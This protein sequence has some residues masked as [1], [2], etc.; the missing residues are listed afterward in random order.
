VALKNYPRYIDPYI[1]DTGRD[2]A[3]DK[4]IAAGFPGKKEV[5]DS[6]EKDFFD[7]LWKYDYKHYWN[8]T[9]RSFREGFDPY[10]TGADADYNYAE[11]I[12]PEKNPLG[13][14]FADAIKDAVAKVSLVR[15]TP[16]SP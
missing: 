6:I 14:V 2:E 8:S 9:Q 10:Y 16:Y 3:R 1:S 4:M 7:A 12:S 11:R 5:V 15:S 13:K